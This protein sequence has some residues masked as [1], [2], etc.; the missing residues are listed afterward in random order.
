LFGGRAVRKGD[1][2]ISWLPQP[3]GQEHRQEASDW[4]LYNL[5]KDPAEQ[6]DFSAQDPEKRQE[7]MAHWDEYVT[8]S[9]VIVSRW[10]MLEI[11][12]R[13]GLPDPYPGHDNFPPTY[14]AEELIRKALE[15]QGRGQ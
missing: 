11:M 3:F 14:G 7:L 5:A 9:N 6:H 4:K 8:Q 1:W 2:K 13:K 12:S 15:K 10:N